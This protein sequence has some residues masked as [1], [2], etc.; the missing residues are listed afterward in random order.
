[1]FTRLKDSWAKHSTVIST[2]QTDF[3]VI[4]LYFPTLM[5]ELLTVKG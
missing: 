4:G 3:P 2:V 1:M 5:L